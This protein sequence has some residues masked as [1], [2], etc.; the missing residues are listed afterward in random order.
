[1][2]L[3]VKTNT[4]I[5]TKI[6]TDWVSI[7]GYLAAV[8]VASSFYMK[9]MIPLRVF[10]IASNICFITY[11]YFSTPI[12]YPVLAL[13][14]FLLPLNIIR[15]RQIQKLVTGVRSYAKGD[16]SL[17]WLVPYMTKEFYS[18]S[19][20]LFKKDDPANKL[21]LIQTGEVHLPELN[22]NVR[23][24]EIVGEIGVLSPYK[25]RTTDAICLEETHLL[26]ITE[27]QVMTLY[28]QNPSFGLFL[29]QMVIKRSIDNY[30][31]LK[32]KFHL[33]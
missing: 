5:I 20:V 29:L 23:A 21:F 27:E 2:I 9:T 11:G 14:L 24:G 22:R 28:Y 4:M 8:L 12:L 10:A 19:S 30:D 25:K 17:E 13:H 33:S 31:A 26:S 15:L 7:V 1:M 6:E 16:Y 18:A 3:L 32:S